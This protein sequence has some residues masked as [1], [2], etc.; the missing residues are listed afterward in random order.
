MPITVSVK[1]N[2]DKVTAEIEA[3][4]AALAAKAAL[5]IEAHAKAL[6]PVDTGLLRNSISAVQLSPFHWLVSSPVHYSAFQEYG[7]SRMAAQPYM[8]PAVEAIRPI[9]ESEAR[10]I[11]A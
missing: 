4:A 10:R 6:A 9:I 7:T 2:L 8:T 5:D 3:R 1:L 11:A